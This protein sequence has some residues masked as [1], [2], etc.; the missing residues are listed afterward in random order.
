MLSGDQIKRIRLSRGLAQSAVAKECGVGRD[1]ISKIENYRLIP[2]EELYE[3]I[4]KAIYTLED[5]TKK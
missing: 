4:I 3:K 1:A 5:K 2:S